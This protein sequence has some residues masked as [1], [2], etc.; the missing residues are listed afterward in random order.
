MSFSPCELQTVLL[1]MVFVFFFVFVIVFVVVFVCNCLCL[2]IL[3]LRAPDCSSPRGRVG[4]APAARATWWCSAGSK[5]G[6]I[7]SPFR[8]HNQRYII[9][10]SSSSSW[11]TSSPSSSWSTSSSSSL[12]QSR[13]GH[14][15][16][17]LCASGAQLGSRKWWFFVTAKQTHTSS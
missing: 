7:I 12:G 4:C 8:F 2:V 17:S 1:D 10:S 14:A 3:T 9:S 13:Q 11:S 6:K 15:G 5:S 16:C